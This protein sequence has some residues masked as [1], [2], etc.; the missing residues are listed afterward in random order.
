MY[1]FGV[2]MCGHV[3]MWVCWCIGVWVRDTVHACHST[4]MEARRQ[5][6][7]FSQLPLRRVAAG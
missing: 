4:S 7:E 6:S 3:S 5:S 2:C 1:L